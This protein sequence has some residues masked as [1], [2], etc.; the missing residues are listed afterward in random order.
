MQNQQPNTASGSTSTPVP[1]GGYG[2]SGTFDYSSPSSEDTSDEEAVR[3]YFSDARV[4]VGY[5]VP[6][7]DLTQMA[8]YAY[9]QKRLERKHPNGFPTMVW[10][11]QY[12]PRGDSSSDDDG[13]G[14][15]EKQQRRLKERGEE[16]THPAVDDS[17]PH[18]D[19]CGRG[20]PPSDRQRIVKAARALGMR[21]VPADLYGAEW[22]L[23]RMRTPL[24]NH[25][26][27]GV[28]WMV[29]RE[30][31]RRRPRGGLLA[32]TMGMGKVWHSV[33]R[34]VEVGFT[35]D[36]CGKTIQAIATI[37]RNPPTAAPTVT[38][39][40]TPFALLE[41]WRAEI[42]RHCMQDALRVHVHHGAHKLLAADAFHQFDVVLCTY[43]GV[44]HSFPQQPHHPLL[45]DLNKEQERRWWSKRGVLHRVNFWRV[46]L[47]ESQHVKNSLGQ[48]S[49]ACQALSAVNTWALSGTP[50]QN[51]LEDILP[52]VRF[53]R[54]PRFAA[55][56]DWR[57]L[58]GPV[59]EKDTI[60]KAQRVK[61]MLKG[62]MLRRTKDDKLLGKPLITLPE[63]RV[64]IRWIKLLPQQWAAYQHTEDVAITVVNQ[65]IKDGTVMSNALGVLSQIMRLRQICNHPYLA[66][67]SSPR[68][69]AFPPPPAFAG[70]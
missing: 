52:I 15:G 28:H 36:G 1:A 70:H 64:G 38:L 41:Y 14:K 19:E 8:D 55:L 3:A 54:H 53:L 63:K 60:E 16:C 4:A 69:P 34:G 66:R 18:C 29:S 9:Q 57:G 65:Y 45:P 2:N 12:I 62:F 11:D 7:Y 21:K 39:I 59:A 40:V 5:H 27:L 6:D 68:P 26:V 22:V 56:Q 42:E 31:R 37:C 10:Q 32:D 24:M 67:K 48:T 23:P 25:Q 49:L 44:L 35:A 50:I 47:D 17:F 13:D 30:Q 61:H 51:R 20:R 58:M 33:A 43:Q 46:I